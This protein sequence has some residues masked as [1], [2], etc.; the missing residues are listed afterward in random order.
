MAMAGDAA[1]DLMRFCVNNLMSM[2]RLGASPRNTLAQNT[3]CND[4][5]PQCEMGR[6]GLRNGPFRIVIRA[7]LPFRPA[8][9]RNGPGRQPFDCSISTMQSE[10]DRNGSHYLHGEAG[11]LLVQQPIAW[12]HRGHKRAFTTN[13]LKQQNL[14]DFVYR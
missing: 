8:M 1:T 3:L 4:A 2:P 10:A 5:F 9:A 7:V 14:H 13:G 11:C 12:E 6:F